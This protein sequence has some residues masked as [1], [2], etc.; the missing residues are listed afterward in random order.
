MN[1]RSFLIRIAQVTLGGIV[2]AALPGSLIA[3][4]RAADPET[5]ALGKLFRGTRQGQVLESLDGGQTWHPRANFGKH[6]AILA[7]RERGGQLYVQVGVQRN[8]FYL[9]S[10]DARTWYTVEQAG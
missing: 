3:A 10:S 5:A 6:C 4:V 2:A 8:S 7:L 1:R 9:R